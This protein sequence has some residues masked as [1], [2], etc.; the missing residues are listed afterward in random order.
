MAEQ[1]S[2]GH[3]SHGLTSKKRY[4]DEE[5]AHAA[6][7]KQPKRARKVSNSTQVAPME[8]TDPA[9]EKPEE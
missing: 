5:N 9:K 4:R 1:A 6:N 8:S 7:D 2:V 3:G